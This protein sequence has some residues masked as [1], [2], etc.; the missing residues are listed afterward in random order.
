MPKCILGH[1]GRHRAV[2]ELHDQ[3]PAWVNEGDAGDDAAQ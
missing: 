3:I 1:A 2:A